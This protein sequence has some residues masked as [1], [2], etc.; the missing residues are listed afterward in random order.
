M[1]DELTV[2]QLQPSDQD[3]ARRLILSGLAERWGSLDPSLNDDL[4]DIASS[5]AE[6]LFLVVLRG[7]ELVGTGALVRESEGVARIVRMSVARPLRRHGVG[8]RIC[9]RLCDDARALGYR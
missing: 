2:R 7:D 4:D 6:G 9:R 1:T 3:A 5:Y 8:R